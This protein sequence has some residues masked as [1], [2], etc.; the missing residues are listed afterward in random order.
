VSVAATVEQVLFDQSVQ[1]PLDQLKP[2]PKNPR[3][4]N[5]EA[6]RESI[7]EN[8]LFYPLVVDDRNEQVLSGNHTLKALV[9]EGWQTVPVLR[10]KVDDDAHAARIVLAANR[11]ND[12]AT[13]NTDLLAE[14]LKGLDAPVGTG[15][16]QDDY[17]RLLEAVVDSSAEDIDAVLRPPI[18]ITKQE[19]AD[20]DGLRVD[21]GG[22]AG[23]LDGD[24][25]DEPDS[26][27]DPEDLRDELGELQGILQLREDMTFASSNYYGIP[28]LNPGGLLKSLADI[29]PIDTWAG[30]EATPDDGKTWW[31]WNYGV[32]PRKGLPMD[33]AILCFY[34]YDTYFEGWWNEPAFYT[35]KAINAGVKYVV[36]PD[37]S[38]YSD[39][40][41]ATWV[42]NQYRAQWLG[43]YF[44]EAGMTVIPRLQFSN[45][46]KDSASLDFCMAGIPKNTGVLAFCSHNS[47]TK[48]EEDIDAHNLTKCLEALTPKS[49][50]VYGGGPAKRLIEAV[51]PVGKGL[52]GDV[53]RVDNY[54]AKRR[55]VV[56]D[57]KEGLKARYKDKKRVGRDRTST[58]DDK[59][60]LV[61]KKDV[62]PDDDADDATL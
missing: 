44:Q 21:G 38:F 41:C 3:V 57:K 42:F 34:T 56:Y 62:K 4:G 20:F 1:M 40:A 47:N 35:A 23:P 36:V 46:K 19:E 31:I 30:E 16:S 10:V 60:A 17:D 48:E 18:T 27:E 39:M 49:L 14:V 6:I 24:E 55:G 13:Y 37:Y 22:A 59:A 32:A 28:D 9:E 29:S 52:V 54:A 45:D 5:V 50:L 43:R 51:D 2:Y 33:R 8:G 12:L 53:V 58:E 11:T 7:R 15:Y 25:D 61:A 26:G